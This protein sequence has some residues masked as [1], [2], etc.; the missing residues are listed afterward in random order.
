MG[1]PRRL[2]EGGGTSRRYHALFCVLLKAGLRP[3]EALALR[4]EDVELKSKTL[5]VEHAVTI[6]GR[7]KDTKSH[8][9]RTVDLSVDLAIPATDG[10]L[11]DRDHVAWVSRAF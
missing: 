1:R 7:V 10:T 11:M 2:P 8:A 3:G 4:L 5:R 6:G 9:G